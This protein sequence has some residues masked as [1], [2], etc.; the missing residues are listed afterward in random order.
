MSVG[1]PA[2][3]LQGVGVMIVRKRYSSIGLQRDVPLVIMSMC[4]STAPDVGMVAVGP[5]AFA[6]RTTVLVKDISPAR[7][8]G[9][10]L[11][12]LR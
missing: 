10:D 8:V 5:A 3:W 9:M 7:P 12:T 2:I 4:R 6:V 1:L 11:I